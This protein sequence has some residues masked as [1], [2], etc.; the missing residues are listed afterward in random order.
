MIKDIMSA[1]QRASDMMYLVEKKM[2]SMNSEVISTRDRVK[3]L[4]SRGT[5]DADA[6]CRAEDKARYT[7]LAF[8]DSGLNELK[9]VLDRL[10]RR[11][12]LIHSTY[13]DGVLDTPVRQELE[14]SINQVNSDLN[15]IDKSLVQL[16]VA[17][18]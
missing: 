17:A 18:V 10:M 1:H 15:S 6:L 13:G 8:N 5:V 9:S 16:E 3:A 2:A 7:K 11:I 4:R 12:E 14:W